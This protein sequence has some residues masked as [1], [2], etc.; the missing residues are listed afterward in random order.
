[1]TDSALYTGSMSAKNLLNSMRLI[2]NNLANINTNG[3][4][5]DYETV[6]SEKK[7]TSISETR[8]MPSTS[9]TYTDFKTGPINYTGRELDVAIDGPGFIAVQSKTGEAALTRAGS[10]NINPQGLLITSKGDMVLG[11]SGPISIPNA[12]DVS[13]DKHGILSARVSGEAGI[14]LAEVGR[15]QLMEIAPENVSKGEDGLYYPKG[16]AAAAVS[17]NVRLIPESIEGSNVDGI[18]SLTELIELSRQFDMHTKHINAVEEN[19]IKANKLLDL[20]S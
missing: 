19:A 6:I 11:A 7:L 1:M 12:S 4:H 13:I 9:Q 17:L 3:F 18:R 15:I 16:D 14:T 20:Q 2:A 5:A 8:I 10:L